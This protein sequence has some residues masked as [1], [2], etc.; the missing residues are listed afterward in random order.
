MKMR[1]V[2]LAVLGTI[3]SAFV[4]PAHTQV[5]EQTAREQARGIVRAELSAK[6]HFKADQ[7][8]GIYRDEDLELSLAIAAVGWRGG[9]WFIYNIS[10]TGVE[11]KEDVIVNHVATDAD[12]MYL[13]AVNAANGTAYRVHG[14]GLAE[15]L[16]EFQKLLTAA[17]IAVSSTDQAEALADFYRKVN[18]ENYQDLTPISSLIELKQAA[19]R[20]C[21]TS[22]FDA[23][24]KAFDAWW[25]GGKARFEKIPF[26]QTATSKGSGYFVEW[27][28]LSSSG[29]GEACGGAPLRARLE[30]NRDGQ[31]GR[32]TFLPLKDVS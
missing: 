32:L 17:K 3:L 26:R 8:L 4:L 12:F 22:S 13:V 18:P 11:I 14:F 7:F 15:S 16:A 1:K 2:L 31:V 29:P 23:S 10:P 5:T 28:V 27:V 19:E 9:P 30:V 25:N 20:K 21:Q 6:V 24:E